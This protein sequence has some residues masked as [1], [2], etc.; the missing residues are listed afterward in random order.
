MIVYGL[1]NYFHQVCDSGRKIEEI[2]NIIGYCDRDTTYAI[3]Y[4]NYIEP[5]E[6]CNVKYDFI[7]ITSIYCRE[8]VNDLVDIWDL[9]CEK[10]IIWEAE[11][12]KRQYI[13]NHGTIF[14]FAQFGEDYIINNILSEKGIPK[15]QAH[16]IEVGVDNPFISNNT[17]FLHLSGARGILVEAN[18][19]SIALIKT[20][21]KGQRIL[22]NAI[23]EDKGEVEFY[24]ADIP[25][26]SS[27]DIENIKLNN[28]CIKRKIMIESISLNDV[29]AIQS[30]TV[31]LSIDLEGYDKAALMSVNFDRYKPEVICAEVGEPDKELLE[32]M[33]T[34]EYD[35]VFCNY[36]NSIWKRRN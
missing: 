35:F 11:K 24:I 18:P 17:Y 7:V 19:E 2:Y 32:Y 10:L 8:I 29:F 1:G 15:E 28:G 3:T 27:L 12:R 16:Y 14:S 23:G 6:L 30:N 34:K 4:L 9:D 25:A 26:L 13:N 31:V 5:K 22:N 21:R 36:I 33:E 20:V